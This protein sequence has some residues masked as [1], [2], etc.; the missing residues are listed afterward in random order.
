MKLVLN[1]C[2]VDSLGGVK[3]FKN[4]VNQFIANKNKLLILYS[5]E[6]QISEIDFNENVV[7]KK[8]SLKR[9]FHPFLNLFL[10]KKIKNLIKKRDRL[11]HH[12]EI[13]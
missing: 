9:F 12:S 5:N 4:S 1:A 3:L 11:Y 8:I 6:K 7:L 2:G 10:D 13:I